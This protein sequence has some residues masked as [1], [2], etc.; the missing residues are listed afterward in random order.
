MPKMSRLQLEVKII[1][2]KP[3]TGCL[4]GVLVIQNLKLDTLYSI[5]IR[6]T[7]KSWIGRR[8]QRTSTS[9]S[10]LIQIMGVTDKQRN[11]MPTEVLSQISI[12][13]LNENPEVHAE[14]F[15]LQLPK[16][17]SLTCYDFGKIGK[18]S[19]K[20]EIKCFTS[21]C[22]F[23]QRELFPLTLP[24]FK[25]TERMSQTESKSIILKLHLIDKNL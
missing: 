23:F 24:I 7:G 19:S 2:F 6:Y 14:Y 22:G 9:N 5:S 13:V 16:Y 3:D 1:D 12:F 25:P 20:I 10:K 21:E 8:F 15:E 4:A 18:G 17:A 11:Q